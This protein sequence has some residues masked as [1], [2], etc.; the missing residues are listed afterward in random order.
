MII[1]L[2]MNPCWDKTVSLPRFQPNAPNRVDVERLDVGG[3]GVNVARTVKD[4]GEE[5]ELVGFD[6]K[7]EPIKEAMA[8]EGI[9]CT[10]FPLKGDMPINTKL[11]ETETGRTLE[12]SERGVTVS[13]DD[14]KAVLYGLLAA[15][16]TGAWFALSGSLPPGAGPDT[17]RRF[18][19]AIQAW[20]CPVAVACGGEALR[21]AVQ[22]KPAL[23]KLSIQDFSALTGIDPENAEDALNA[24]R[25]LC[26]QGVG[27]VCLT[28]SGKTAW[29]VSLKGAWAC[30]MTNAGTQNAPDGDTLLAALLVALSRGMIDP[31]ALRFASVAAVIPPGTRLCQR[32]EIDALFPELIARPLDI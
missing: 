18:C 13:E 11:W 29:L 5:T 17:Y 32:K 25:R 20:N 2:S 8:R 21:E 19:A 24:C 12:I 3:K 31:D 15:A 6:Y 23:V 30:D 7:G 1:P 14:L 4:L 9:A 10:L 22:A 27:R 16:R 26:F 28:W